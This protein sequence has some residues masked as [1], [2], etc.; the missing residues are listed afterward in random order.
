MAPRFTSTGFIP[1]VSRQIFVRRG[2][3]RSLPL[4]SEGIPAAGMELALASLLF[5]QDQ[6]SLFSD[7]S[8]RRE[9]YSVKGLR[10]DVYLVWSNSEQQFIVVPA[11]QS[12]LQR[13]DSRAA[14]GFGKAN[15]GKQGTVHTRPDATRCTQ[16][17]Q[18][19]GKSIGE[20]HH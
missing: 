8:D 16:P 17:Q 14:T 18:V 13:V 4:D 15:D 20:V 3:R 12:Q 6:L 1:K 19:S 2:A 9:R 7:S 11:M 5:Q 10:Q